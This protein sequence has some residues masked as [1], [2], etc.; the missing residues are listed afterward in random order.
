MIECQ[1]K[2][3]CQ[4]SESA[5]EKQLLLHIN[6]NHLQ[7]NH[8]QSAYKTAHLTGTALLSIRNEIHLSLSRGEPTALVLFDPLAAFGTI[9]H[10]TL[11]S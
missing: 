1:V 6:D 4:I 7:Y 5:V 11:V 8:I 2:A 9:D 3:E 10:A